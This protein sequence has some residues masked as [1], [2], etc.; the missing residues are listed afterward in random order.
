MRRNPICGV[1]PDER[2]IFTAAANV[3]EDLP[4]WLA[5]T[6]FDRRMTLGDVADEI[7]ISIP[8]VSRAERGHNSN[9]DTTVK[10]LRWL[11]SA[12]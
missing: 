4:R 10:I 1:S 5:A 2:H 6:R 8:A 12:A 3:L 9:T 7:G 11:G